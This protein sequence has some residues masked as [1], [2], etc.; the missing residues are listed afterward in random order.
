[1][2]V[3]KER[4]LG[5]AGTHNIIMC[6][7][8]AQ[9]PS[10]AWPRRRNLSTTAAATS[11]AVAVSPVVARGVIGERVR[12]RK[13]DDG[14]RFWRGEVFVCTRVYMCVCVSTQVYGGGVSHKTEQHNHT[15]CPAY[16]LHTHSHARTN[17]HGH[18]PIYTMYT[19]TDAPSHTTVAMTTDPRHLHISPKIACGLFIFYQ[20]SRA[21]FFIF[22]FFSCPF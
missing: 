5:A 13:S 6:K 18:S 22:F 9:A 8:H 4:G 3:T 17:T 19:H 2:Y 21:I 14:A 7:A 11:T 20:F 12:E 1:M 10:A 16:Y 15:A